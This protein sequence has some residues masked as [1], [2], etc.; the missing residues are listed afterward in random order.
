MIIVFVVYSYYV[1]HVVLSNKVGGGA[2]AAACHMFVDDFH[3]EPASAST[4]FNASCCS[5]SAARVNKHA[6]GEMKRPKRI[7]GSSGPP[8]AGWDVESRGQLK[9]AATQRM[10]LDGWNFCALGLTW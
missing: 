8:V 6:G 5:M 1:Q 7:C 4:P 9:A 2:A 3:T 10:Q